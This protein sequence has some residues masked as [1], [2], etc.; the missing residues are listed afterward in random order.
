MSG[1]VVGPQHNSNDLHATFGGVPARLQKRPAIATLVLFLLF[2]WGHVQAATFVGISGFHLVSNKGVLSTSAAK[3]GQ[4]P[5]VLQ[6]ETDLPLS[7]SLS[8]PNTHTVVLQLHEARFMDGLFS[9]GQ[10]PVAQLPTG[11]TRVTWIPPKQPGQHGQLML[12]GPKLAQRRLLVQGATP[13]EWPNAPDKPTATNVAASPKNAGFSLGDSAIVSAVATTYTATRESSGYEEPLTQ[14]TTASSR[15]ITA[16]E[17]TGWL[18]ASTG[19]LTP[20]QGTIGDVLQSLSSSPSPMAPSTSQA[21]FYTPPEPAMEPL[22]PLLPSPPS[23]DA[24]L[25]SQPITRHKSVTTT[26]N[27]SSSL[28]YT[29][30]GG[31]GSS[32]SAKPIVLSEASDAPSAEPIIRN[33][34][35]VL[36][37][38]EAQDWPLTH[39]R[40]LGLLKTSPQQPSLWALLGELYLTTQQPNDA[41]QAFEHALALEPTLTTQGVY[42]DRWAVSL[43]QWP[44]VLAAWNHW[45]Q[46]APNWAS[47]IQQHYL[48]NTVGGT[49][50]TAAGQTEIAATYWS[51]AVDLEPTSLEART[52]L[53]LLLELQ[54]QPEAALAQYQAASRLN[55]LDDASRQGI[56]RLQSVA[57]NP[58]TTTTLVGVEEPHTSEPNSN[59][60]AT[61]KQR[62]FQPTIPLRFQR[63]P[64]FDAGGFRPF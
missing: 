39:Q 13:M 37:A 52:Q 15:L 5:L 17:P 57:A 6:F 62:R 27:E 33:L 63:P 36:Q 64:A 19:T 8:V 3:Q 7:Y 45:Q 30:K 34:S 61:K 23:L 43:Y 18:D 59:P 1:R 11:V 47:V 46:M 9:N 35:P 54:Q 10:L 48:A 2:L 32:Q 53:A 4:Q 12:V 60:S 40:L 55:P 42:V 29:I 56:A 21:T 26:R 22:R 24:L 20:A 44:D 31:D 14:G 41:T 50:A 38:F 28:T 58:S 49:L 51:R 25:A 16:P